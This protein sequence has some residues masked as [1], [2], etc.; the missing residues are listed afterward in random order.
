[1]DTEKE[2]AKPKI[3][4]R[5]RIKLSMSEKRVFNLQNQIERRGEEMENISK[6][7]EQIKEK[8]LEAKKREESEKPKLT[9]ELIRQIKLSYGYSRENK[10]KLG[11]LESSSEMSIQEILVKLG[12][13]IDLIDYESEINRIKERLSMMWQKIGSFKSSNPSQV[14]SS[15]EP[16]PSDQMLFPPENVEQKALIKKLQRSLN[17]LRG[18]IDHLNNRADNLQIS[19]S[20][21]QESIKTLTSTLNMKELK[22]NLNT[23]SDRLVSL[24]SQPPPEAPAPIPDP[25]PPRKSSI[26]HSKSSKAPTP[27]SSTPRASKPAL[28]NYTV[29]TPWE[30]S[31]QLAPS[32]IIINNNAPKL[33]T[34][35][36]LNDLDRKIDDITKELRKLIDTNEN[37][38]QKFKTS[39][40]K[41][42]ER[43]DQSIL[44]I[45]TRVTALE[46]RVDSLENEDLKGKTIDTG[47][48]KKRGRV[49]KGQL[50]EALQIA[51]KLVEDFKVMRKEVFDRLYQIT[52]KELKGKASRRELL[53]I[54]TRF[55]ERFR[56]FD[57]DAERFRDGFKQSIQRLQDRISVQRTRRATSPDGDF[58]SSAILSKR[59]DKEFKCMNCDKT[60]GQ[61]DKV[62]Q[63]YSQWKNMPSKTKK[64]KMLH[65]GKGYSKLLQSYNQE[66][67]S[68]DN[69]FRKEYNSDTETVPFQNSVIKTIDNRELDPSGLDLECKKL[70]Q[71][72]STRNLKKF[73]DSA[74]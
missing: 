3:L 64:G 37:E 46:V 18:N 19:Y 35:K 58:D 11:K 60:L 44:S 10:E 21:Q 6:L 43:Q 27:K 8:Q 51:E 66:I 20:K 25:T 48:G 67:F 61:L 56:G 69:S 12:N 53:E 34:E 49:D 63:S 71:I 31:Q 2:V 42:L 28:I 29:S 22:K 32:R 52:E 5:K 17:E 4:D 45:L 39:A 16:E 54:E 38:F 1:M 55:E 30:R 24:E 14:T 40:C 7:L 50:L 41:I 9:Q 57:K 36:S 15:K 33:E 73:N 13:K 59:R 62:Q 26:S 74:K 65:M 70:P 72:R 47:L 68:P 23:L